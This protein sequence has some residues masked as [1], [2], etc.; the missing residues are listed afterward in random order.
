MAD[1]DTV[2]GTSHSARRTTATA[3]AKQKVQA[4][5]K[6]LRDPERE[7]TP[8]D[9]AS[10]APLRRVASGSHRT[11]SSARTSHERR[12]ER[13]TTEAI[14]GAA[15]EYQAVKDTPRSATY[16][17]MQTDLPSKRARGRASSR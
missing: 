12:T 10:N 8:Q 9:S 2:R 4:T 13:A 5:Q 3:G 6:G 7:V 15:D 1:L 17:A 11:K 14:D 16:L